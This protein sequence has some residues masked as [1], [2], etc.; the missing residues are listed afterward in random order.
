MSD[1]KK[2]FF[3]CTVR[4]QYQSLNEGSGVPTLRSYEEIFTLPSQ[5]AALSLICKHLL[6]PRLRKTHADFIRFRTHELVGIK[7]FNYSPNKDVLQMSMD[8]MDISELYDFCIL[9]QIMID[10]YQHKDKDIFA[11]RTMIQK[12]Y[13]DKRQA[14]KEKKESTQGVEQ[15]KADELRKLNDLEP[16]D[17][18]L[19][20]NINEQKL[21]NNRQVVDKASSPTIVAT[22]VGEYVEPLDEPL[23]PVE[24]DE[25][26]LE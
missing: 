24:L 8:D 10:P 26:I 4:G 22:P 25:P 6:A 5:E 1:G 13:S 9:R 12:V 20:V 17:K 19:V 3:E 23:P 2:R 15:I 16:G 11:L 14:L 21:T 7:L 18:D